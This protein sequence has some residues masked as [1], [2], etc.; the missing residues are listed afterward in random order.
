MYRHVLP[1]LQMVLV[2]TATQLAIDLRHGATQLNP[3][4]LSKVEAVVPQQSGSLLQLR[5]G[6][7]IKVLLHYYHLQVVTRRVDTHQPV[8][9]GTTPIR[10]E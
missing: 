6:N 1:D 3:L 2:V 7:V 10:E 4:S 8:N 5:S 9:S